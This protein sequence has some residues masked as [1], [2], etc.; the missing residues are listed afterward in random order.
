MA[1][2]SLM[3][4]ITPISSNNN[5]IPYGLE[6]KSN[7]DIIIEQNIAPKKSTKTPRINNKKSKNNLLI[8]EQPQERMVNHSVNVTTPDEPNLKKPVRNSYDV[9]LTLV[10]RE[11]IAAIDSAN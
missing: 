11:N 7:N 8:T 10:Q 6:S 9:K 1:S 3:D 4:K 5:I 2:K